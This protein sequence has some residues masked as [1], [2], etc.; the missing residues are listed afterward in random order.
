MTYKKLRR[1]AR[2]AFRKKMKEA[3]LKFAETIDFSNGI[4]YTWNKARILNNSWVNVKSSSPQYYKNY[5][6]KIE[7]ALNDL[8]P[9][10]VSDNVDS[11]EVTYDI[12]YDSFFNRP[13]T[14]TDYNMASSS[15]GDK[16]SPGR[17]ELWIIEILI[18]KVPFLA[19]RYLECHVRMW[20][21]S[22]S[23]AE[24]IRSL[25]GEALR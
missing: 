10:S 14:Y 19:C 2:K 22:W 15:R 8:C 3:F 4:G 18:F 11:Y 25:R 20:H 5:A 12:S 21:L 7:E 24:F 16:S 13:F 9:H 1:E 17:G 23:M 6:A